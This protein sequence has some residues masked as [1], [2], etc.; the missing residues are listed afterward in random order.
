ML[1][2]LRYLG[3]LRECAATTHALGN[4]GRTVGCFSSP[5]AASPVERR[6]VLDA[7]RVAG[8]VD[9]QVFS[10]A[11]CL[12]A[13]YA[14]KHPV[15]PGSK[16]ETVIMVDVGQLQTTVVVASFG[17]SEG[18]VAEATKNL[19]AGCPYSVLGVRSDE[20]L[21]ASH[22]DGKMFQHFRGMVK[23]KYSHDV[24]PGSKQGLRLLLACRCL[25]ELLSTTPTAET[26][27]E[28]R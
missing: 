21:G 4:V 9:A 22:F 12:C 20:D 24:I 26:A 17:E 23:K 16:S 27:V 3:K 1:L 18:G 6:A 25:R 13:V 5:V 19:P 11:D 8:F 10:A 15:S 28:V 2:L 7:A 14:R